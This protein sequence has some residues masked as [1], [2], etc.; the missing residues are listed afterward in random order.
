MIKECRQMDFA[1]ADVGN[2]EVG[3]KLWEFSEKMIEE[4]EKESAVLRALEKKE[5]E[6]EK[7]KKEVA[8]KK[9]KKTEGSRRSR[10]AQK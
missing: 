5:A 8:E 4:A 6:V 1:R 2:D 10:K 3:K 9:G 7:A